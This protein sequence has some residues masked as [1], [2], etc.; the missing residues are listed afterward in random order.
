MRSTVRYRTVPACT[1][2]TSTRS[3][4]VNKPADNRRACEWGATGKLLEEYTLTQ[5]VC[6]MIRKHLES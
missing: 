4:K 6:K 1:Y 3:A 2:R 5:S